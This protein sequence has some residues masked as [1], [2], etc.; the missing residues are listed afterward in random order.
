LSMDRES[1]IAQQFVTNDA[2]IGTRGRDEGNGTNR[3]R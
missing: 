1:R 2:G 3:S